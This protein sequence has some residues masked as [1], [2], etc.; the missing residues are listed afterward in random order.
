MAEASPSQKG[1]RVLQLQKPAKRQRMLLQ[2]STATESL[3][4]R[5][6]RTGDLMRMTVC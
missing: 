5:S 3:I 6:R 4:R 2:V 1:M